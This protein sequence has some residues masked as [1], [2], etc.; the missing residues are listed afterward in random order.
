MPALSRVAGMVTQFTQSAKVAVFSKTTCPFSLRVKALLDSNKIEYQAMELDTLSPEEMEA[1]Q[2]YLKQET[3]I[4]TVPNVWIHGKFAGD[5]GQIQG[6]LDEKKLFS[7][8][9]NH[10]Y[11]YDLIVIGGG[12]GGL[13]ASKRASKLGRKVV[14]LDYVEQTPIGTQWGLGG[15][16]VNVGCIP[17]KLMHQ[18]AIQGHNIQD[19]AK[20]GWKL[21]E[22]K[23]ENSWE[24]LKDNVNNYI[25]SINWGYR[26]ELREEKVDYLNKFGKFVDKNTICCVDKKG[27]E[28]TITG[29]D[30]LIAVGERPSYP[31]EIDPKYVI[32]SDD[33]FRLPYN[34]GKTLIIGASYIALECAGFLRIWS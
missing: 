31:P 23:I 11:D 8:V 30:I 24:E 7:M 19:S 33:L 15:T 21:P 14:V 20:F 34:P 10:G 4:R 5:S 26:V 17:K 3:G 22:G 6:L 1:T 27:R 13:S 29:Q 12:S 16:C 32:S 18:A 9:N 25:G 2:D 28:Q